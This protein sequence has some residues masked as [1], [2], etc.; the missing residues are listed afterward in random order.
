MDYTKEIYEGQRQINGA[1]CRADWKVIQALRLIHNILADLRP[2]VAQDVLGQLERAIAEADDVSGKV[3]GFKP[4][5]CEPETREDTT[6]TH[7]ATS[8]TSTQ[9]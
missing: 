3:A 8:Y 9:P 5:G 6:Y 4:P 7:A 2:H 1:L